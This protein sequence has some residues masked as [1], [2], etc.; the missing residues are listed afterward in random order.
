MIDKATRNKNIELLLL[1]NYDSFT[2]NLYDYFGQLGISCT[3]VR[4]DKITITEIKERK[5]DGIVLSPGP[6]RPHNS[7]VLMELVHVLHLNLPILGVCLGMHALGE[8]FGAKLVHAIVPMHGKTS[9]VFHN[10]QGLFDNINSPT[11]VMRYHSL[12]LNDLPSCLVPMAWT[13][14]GE[15]MAFQHKSLP[16]WAVQFHPESILTKDGLGILNNWVKTCFRSE[17]VLK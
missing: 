1:D 17:I 14:E 4:N 7:G 2:Y 15:L 9:L 5:F 10:M 3:V 6:Q 16:L 8:Y 13:E 11:E 12:V